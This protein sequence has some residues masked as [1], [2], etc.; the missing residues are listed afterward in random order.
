MHFLVLCK[1][2]KVVKDKVLKDQQDQ[3]DQQDQRD[4]EDPE[5]QQLLNCCQH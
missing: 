4:P 5:D 3:Q 2:D 1:S